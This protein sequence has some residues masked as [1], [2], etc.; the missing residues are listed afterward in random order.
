M[1]EDN[2]H[3]PAWKRLGL[4]L[5][6]ANEQPGEQPRKRKSVSFTEGIIH[7]P[8]EKRRRK[9]DG[10][11]DG[12]SNSDGRVKTDGKNMDDKKAKNNAKLKT[13]GEVKIEGNAK[14]DKIAKSNEKTTTDT[15]AKKKRDKKSANTGPE[16]R[17][18]LVQYLELYHKDRPN[19]KFNKAKQNHLL[20]NLY[21]FQILPDEY[22]EAIIMYLDG[23]QG[24]G[25]RKRVKDE[26]DAVVENGPEGNSKKDKRALEIQKKLS[27]AETPKPAKKNRKS[28]T[29]VKS[30]T[31]SDESSSS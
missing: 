3:V 14:S 11:S 26:A 31:S 15:K 2:G 18:D 6:Y 8:P 10:G 13:N 28:R 1:A 4:K 23:L 20:K 19:W 29:L 24:E 27:V 22:D 25:V 21:N 9:G 7:T 16:D 30:D 12:L 17:S 5:K